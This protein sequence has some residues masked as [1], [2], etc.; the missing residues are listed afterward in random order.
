MTSPRM[1]FA[2]NSLIFLRDALDLAIAELRNQI[3]T[4]PNVI[5][6]SDDIDA[7]EEDISHIERII[8]RI[9]AKFGELK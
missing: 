1:T 6:Y 3:A 8:T 4:C 9:D 2:G 5:R 7:C